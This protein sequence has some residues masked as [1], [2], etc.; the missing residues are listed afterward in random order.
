MAFP[1]PP[2]TNGQQHTEEGILY[3]WSTTEN[4]WNIVLDGAQELILSNVDPTPADVQPLGSV[5]RNTVTG[6]AWEYSTNRD[7]ASSEWVG[8]YSDNDIQID[9]ASPTFQ[10]DGSS[11]QPGDLWVDSSVPG[12]E[13][14]KYR[15][16]GNTWED[17]KT[18]FDN[19]TAQ[20][21][22]APTNTQSAID[23][24]AS[25]ISILV[26]GLSFYGT[27]DASTDF[28]DYVPSSGLVDGGLPA[29][30]PLTNKDT[31]L[32]VTVDGTPATGTLAGQPM[33]SGDW[34]ISDGTTWTWLDLTTSVSNF[35]GHPDTPNSYAGEAGKIA[36]VNTAETGLEFVSVTDTHSILAS[37]TTYPLPTGPTFRDPPINSVAVT[38]GD[39]WID[40]DT[41]NPYTYTTSGWQPLVPVI[42]DTATPTTTTAGSLWYNPSTAVLSVRD[43]VANSWVGF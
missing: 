13:I 9:S 8:I 3:Q 26:K 37:A 12:D 31:Y 16:S 32:V 43:P 4:C 41:L 25:R 10:H 6:D 24:M 1:T 15:S 40:S 11:L 21:S 23:V 19:T 27:Y 34:L 22:G 30:D 39:R 2:F 7:T 35:L 42:I 28:V 33:S 38:L 14:V 17:L 29:A 20:L 18:S 5:W 36:R